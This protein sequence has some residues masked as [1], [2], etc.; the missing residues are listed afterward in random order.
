MERARK[1]NNKNRLIS[2]VSNLHFHLPSHFGESAKFPLLNCPARKCLLLRDS[3]VSFDFGNRIWYDDNA[4]RAGSVK[5]GRPNTRHNKMRVVQ[6]FRFQFRFLNL[7]NLVISLFYYLKFRQR[8]QC[9]TEKFLA[10][11]SR[12]F[13]HSVNHFTKAHFTLAGKK[14]IASSF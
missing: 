4:G 3:H 10:G 5:G 9:T 13:R 7:S 6:L 11:L 2:L 8:L 12:H 1:R 14:R